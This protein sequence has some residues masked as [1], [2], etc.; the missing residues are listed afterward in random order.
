[1][2][3]IDADGSVRVGDCKI[4][5]KRRHFTGGKRA[6]LKTARYSA[7]KKALTFQACKHNNDRFSCVEFT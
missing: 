3:N 7:P 1:M 5:S 6:T 4:G 2:E